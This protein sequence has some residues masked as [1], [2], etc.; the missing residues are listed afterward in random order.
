M[1]IYGDY[2]NFILFAADKCMSLPPKE[3]DNLYDQ[4][5]ARP[6]A[7]DTL[8]M[9]RMTHL[10]QELEPH[11]EFNCLEE[12]GNMLIVPM[13]YMFTALDSADNLVIQLALYTASI[14]PVA[15]SLIG[16]AFKKIGE[17]ENPQS[18]LRLEMLTQAYALS[19]LPLKQLGRSVTG[20]AAAL[21]LGEELFA[22]LDNTQAELIR[23]FERDLSRK[24]HSSEQPFIDN[25]QNLKQQ[26]EQF[27]VLEDKDDGLT[28]EER[29]LRAEGLLKHVIGRGRRE[30]VVSVETQEKA[31]LFI[32][33]NKNFLVF[34]IEQERLSKAM[35]DVIARMPVVRRSA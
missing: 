20:A 16:A 35:A 3:V 11:Y 10:A 30:G 21:S 22:V 29:M 34:V 12:T 28:G 33:Q 5:S 25:L 7:A 27:K 17:V 6:D 2:R 13:Q 31:D 15:L 26:L 32:A 1:S 24:Y 23:L 14:I 4:I 19:D 18:A 8:F 9:D